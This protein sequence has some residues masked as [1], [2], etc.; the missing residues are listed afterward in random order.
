MP[1]KSLKKELDVTYFLTYFGN[2]WF[3]FTNYFLENCN[4][5]KKVMSTLVFEKQNLELAFSNIFEQDFF[6]LIIILGNYLSKF[7]Y[8]G[9]ISSVVYLQYQ[10]CLLHLLICKVLSLLA[11]LKYSYPWSTFVKVYSTNFQVD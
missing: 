8:Q 7:Y 10:C 4:T 6:A 9:S 3:M 5:N 1:R 2:I 11:L